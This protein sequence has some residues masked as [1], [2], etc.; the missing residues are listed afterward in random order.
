MIRGLFQSPTCTG[1]LV[2]GTKGNNVT[3]NVRRSRRKG[4][5]F[6]STASSLGT[7][8][9]ESQGSGGR[10]DPGPTM[11][12]PCVMDLP[13]HK[14]VVLKCFKHGTMSSGVEGHQ[15]K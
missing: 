7:W 5:P 1:F 14:N 13:S 3:A 11:E 10:L 15:P 8:G 9:S 2:Q 6:C 12:I 4:K